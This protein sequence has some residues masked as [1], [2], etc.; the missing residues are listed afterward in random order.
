MS[1]RT[2]EGTDDVEDASTIRRTIQQLLRERDD[3]PTRSEVVIN[4]NLRLDASAPMIAGELDELER[5]G[6][7]YCVGENDPAVKVP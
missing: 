6:L 4:A 3:S 7:V 2:R 1:E 5:N